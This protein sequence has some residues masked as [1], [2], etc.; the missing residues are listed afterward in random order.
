MISDLVRTMLL[1]L[2]AF[3]AA[4]CMTPY[5]PMGGMGGYEQ[6]QLDGNTFSIRFHGNGFT[7]RE[8]VR[9]Y[10][11]RR[12]AEIGKQLGYRYVIFLGEEDRSVTSTYSIPT[13]TYTSGTVSTYGSTGGYSGVSNTYGGI[14]S[15]NKPRVQLIARYFEVLP[16]GRYLEIHEVEEL[17]NQLVPKSEP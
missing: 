7:S 3:F 16:E 2:V 9:K 5:V 8:L 14:Q 1:V 15:V 13:T 12:A 4:S 11:K 10:A 17:Y 6:T